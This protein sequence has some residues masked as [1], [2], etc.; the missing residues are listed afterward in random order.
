MVRE[1]LSFTISAGLLGKAIMR[2]V[3]FTIRKYKYGVCGFLMAS[4]IGHQN[5]LKLFSLEQCVHPLFRG[6]I[7]HYRISK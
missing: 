2:G 5:H 3:I 1:A 7:N 4:G 6:T